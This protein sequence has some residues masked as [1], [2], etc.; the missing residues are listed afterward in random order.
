MENW[1]QVNYQEVFLLFDL[2]I[3]TTQN[4]SNIVAIVAHEFMVSYTFLS[5]VSFSDSKI[6]QITF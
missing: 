3:S 2:L 4:K 5:R 6:S 1:G